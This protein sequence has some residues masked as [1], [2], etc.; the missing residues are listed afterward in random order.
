MAHDNNV[1]PDKDTSP[2]T[3]SFVHKLSDATQYNPLVEL[4]RPVVPQVQLFLLTRSLFN[5]EPSLMTQSSRC[6]LQAH[7]LVLLHDV[8][9]VVFIFK[10]RSL[11]VTS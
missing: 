4:H 8:L 2:G 11:L 6:F 3:K 10:I 9:E 1:D 5:D 7:F